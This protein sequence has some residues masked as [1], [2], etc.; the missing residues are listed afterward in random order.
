MAKLLNSAQMRETDRRT[1]EE[2][3]LPGMVLMENAGQGVVQVLKAK[4][5]DWAQRRALILAGSGNNGG[6]GFVV[7]RRLL[8]DGLMT[9][10]LLFARANTLKGDAAT[11]HQI[12]RRLGGRV[13]E[14]V[15]PEDLDTLPS[16]LGHAGVIIDA[17]FGTGLMRPITGVIATA[18]TMANQAGKPILAV[19]IPSGVN[20]DNGRILGTAI[21]ATWT[22]TFAAEKIGHRLYPGAE[23]C[24]E[25]FLID[26]GIPATYLNHP[27]HVVARNLPRDLTIPPRPKNSHKGHFGHLFIIA[28]SVGKEGAAALTALGAHAAG[29]GLVTVATPG[30]AQPVVATKLLEAMTLPLPDDRVACLSPKALTALLNHPIRPAVVAIGPGLGDGDGTSAVVRGLLDHWPDIPLVIDA[31]GLNAMAHEPQRKLPASRTA[32]TILTPHP[33]EMARLLGQSIA[34]IQ[35]DRLHAAKTLAME[36]RSWVVLKGADSIIAAPDGRQWI[37]DSGN[38]GLAAGGSG[39]ILTGVI[40]GLL[41]RGWPVESAVRAGVHV[42]GL[43]AEEAATA[44]GGAPGLK[45][46][47][48]PPFLRRAINQLG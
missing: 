22:V 47:E 3:G 25:L 4:L 1:I 13:V 34:S 37:N 5:T 35:E 10:V 14:I 12:F 8:Q 28:G 21:Q 38:S 7:A 39:D 2:L 41:A 24:G 48:L 46:G 17:L 42:H 31:D 33:G 11:N 43:A 19:D 30:V 29:P 9:S 27:Q 15:E 40:A 26:I 36:L 45:A 32:P 20:A 16:R 23:Q 6:D 44:F 18:I